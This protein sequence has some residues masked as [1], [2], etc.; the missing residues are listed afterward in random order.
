[1]DGHRGF[2]G[3]NEEADLD[4]GIALALRLHPDTRRIV[5][6]NDTTPSG[7]QV[8][9]RLKQLIAEGRFKVEF[10]LWEDVT[11][12]T[13]ERW[14]AGLTPGDILFYTFFIRD[15]TGTFFEF[16]DSIARIAAKC[17]VPIYGA[18]DFNLGYGIVG[19]MLTGGY[20]QGESACRIALRVLAGEPAE[21]IPVVMKS[22]NRYM[23]DYVQLQRFNIDPTDLPKGSII[24]NQPGNIYGEHRILFGGGLLAIILLHFIIFSLALN[25]LRRR[26]AEAA[27]KK[28]EETLRATFE[29]TEDGLLVTDEMGR[30]RQSNTSF[31]KIW[32]APKT[33]LDT[34]ADQQIMD[35]LLEQLENPEH[36]LLR[37][38]K[39]Q[40]SRFQGEDCRCAVD[41]WR[42]PHC[43]RS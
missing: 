6:V 18:W 35:H 23:F 13:L 33:L 5:V 40:R 36:F 43:F 27:V 17:P 32:Q 41:F 11:M 1:L 34:E 16:D 7:L 30:I 9:R 22:P 20:F 31:Q 14:V 12:E 38:R 21:Q 24:I 8:K 3:V 15:K 19:G 42:W 26:R 2:T 10:R 4:S 25:I 37:A 39:L 29:S 28:S